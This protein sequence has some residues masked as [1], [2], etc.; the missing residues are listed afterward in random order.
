MLSNNHEFNTQMYTHVIY[1]CNYVCMYVCMYVC[2]KI[3][4]LDNWKC[5]KILKTLQF[6][7]FFAVSRFLVGQNC[8]PVVVVDTYLCC[9]CL[10]LCCHY[11]Q[12]QSTRHMHPNL[13][14][15]E[16]SPLLTYYDG[17]WSQKGEECEKLY[18]SPAN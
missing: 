18:F 14:I 11:D 10:C 12:H 1:I 2:I 9:C 15:S 17:W 4:L 6:T 5:G 7:P 16:K 3:N 8:D 13:A